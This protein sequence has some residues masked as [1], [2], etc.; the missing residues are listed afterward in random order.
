MECSMNEL[1][2]AY[3]YWICMDSWRAFHWPLASM[4]WNAVIS[5]ILLTRTNRCC[6]QMK[7]MH[8]LDDPSH[9]AKCEHS[10][11]PDT[12]SMD[13]NHRKLCPDSARTASYW[14]LDTFANCILVCAVCDDGTR[15]LAPS[16]RYATTIGPHRVPTS[17]SVS[18]VSYCE[19]SNR[20]YRECSFQQ[21]TASRS[22][23]CRWLSANCFWPVWKIPNA[24]PCCTV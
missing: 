21:W 20:S 9:W 11:S 12:T 6:C 24:F 22:S 16:W 19:Q 17:Q 1:T 8:Q 13:C 15:R 5:P 7:S 2:S 14:C 10:L 4:A 18:V 3:P 23:R